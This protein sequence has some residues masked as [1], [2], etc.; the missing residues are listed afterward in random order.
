MLE[1][2]LRGTGRGS[3]IVGRNVHNQQIERLW[4]DVFQ[5]VLRLYPG[6]FNYLEYIR[7]LDPDNDIHLLVYTLYICLVLEAT[8]KWKN[9]W[10]ENTPPLK[11]QK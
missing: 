4:C 1:H 9:A 10:P 6:L 2:P 8:S 3:V 11:H 7:L 5:G